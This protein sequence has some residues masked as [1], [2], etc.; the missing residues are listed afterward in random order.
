M[1]GECRGMQG[2]CGYG[3]SERLFRRLTKST[4]GIDSTRA[5][6]SADLLVA[7]TWL[8]SQRSNSLLYLYPKE[9]QI[10]VLVTLT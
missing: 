10:M 5:K 7:L 9:R 6:F 2:K 4:G 3:K 8:F 1:R